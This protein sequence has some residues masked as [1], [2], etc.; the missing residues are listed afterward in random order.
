MLMLAILLPVLVAATLAVGTL[1][2]ALTVKYRDFKHVVPFMVQLW[3]FMTP[4]IYMHGTSSFGWP[5]RALLP[6]N[7]AYGLIVNYRAA[8]LDGQFDFYALIISS[9]T[10]LCL[11]WLSAWYFGRIEREFAD[12][13]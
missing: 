10:S 13:I 1:L 5:L 7:P 12:V 11:L 3:M 6:L 8:V 2:S 9:L 4:A